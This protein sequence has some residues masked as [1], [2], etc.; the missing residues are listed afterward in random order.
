MLGD[1]VGG[2]RDGGDFATLMVEG[3]GRIWRNLEMV[4]GW[5]DRC[6]FLFR[7]GIIFRGRASEMELNYGASFPEISICMAFENK[8]LPMLLVYSNPVIIGIPSDI[9]TF[10]SASVRVR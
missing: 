3:L 4:Y 2:W 7:S 1:W 8:F 6:M 5:C 9:S 10:G